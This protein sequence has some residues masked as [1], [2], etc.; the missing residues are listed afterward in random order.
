MQIDTLEINEVTT[1]TK[2]PWGNYLFHYLITYIITIWDSMNY[3]AFKNLEL[4]PKLIEKIRREPNQT[5]RLNKK[6]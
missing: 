4:I 1:P 3:K 6:K 2:L 5:I